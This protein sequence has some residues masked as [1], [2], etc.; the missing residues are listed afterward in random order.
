MEIEKPPFSI[1]RNGWGEF[2]INITIYFQDVN[3]EPVTKIHA[4]QIF[5]LNQNQRATIKK[6]VVNEDYDEIVFCEPTEFFYHMLTD[7]PNETLKAIGI[8]PAGDSVADPPLELAKEDS[9]SEVKDD[10]AK[11]EIKEDAK[12]DSNQKEDEKD[13]E[14][15]AIKEAEGDMDVD[16]P[17]NKIQ[18]DKADEVPKITPDA[19]MQPDEE[20]KVPPTSDNQ[21]AD[22]QPKEN[23]TI[24][25]EVENKKEE[26]DD[27]IIKSTYEVRVGANNE[28]S[29]DV[30]QFFEDHNDKS[31]VKL[32]S[33]ALKNLKEETEY[34]RGEV[35][36]AEKTLIDKKDKLREF[37]Q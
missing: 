21:V 1:V 18:S 25:Q 9:K 31:D 7:D 4:I 16:I 14:P 28:H 26:D 33:D 29:V 12:E 20:A 13:K 37:D 15:E 8:E 27:I 35:R 10:E 6:P 32:L 3:E 23:E 36:E 2:E 17:D 24:K 34:L 19:E 22:E 30:S 11:E 5:H